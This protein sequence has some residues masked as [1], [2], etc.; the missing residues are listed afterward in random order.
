MPGLAQC[1]GPVGHD[2]MWQPATQKRA[3]ERKARRDHTLLD[4]ITG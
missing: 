3:Q 1:T 2:K 4:A